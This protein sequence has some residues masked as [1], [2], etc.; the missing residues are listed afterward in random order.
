MSEFKGTPGPWL[1]GGVSMQ[2]GAVSVS[3][4]KY[5]IVIASVHNAASFC[6]FISAALR[7]EEFGAPDTAATQFANAR[8]IAA[9]PDLLEALQTLEEVGAL[10]EYI[11]GSTETEEAQRKALAAIRKALGENA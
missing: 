10:R 9:A 6:D 4:A 8:L 7:G 3:H 1:V 11:G 2:D 5:R